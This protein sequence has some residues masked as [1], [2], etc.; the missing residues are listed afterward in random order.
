VPAPTTREEKHQQMR[1]YLLKFGGIADPNELRP[2][3]GVNQNTALLM[4]LKDSFETTRW[5]LLQEGSNLLNNCIVLNC[6]GAL[7]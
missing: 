4:V 7:G 1:E 2:L 5:E 3:T 6:E